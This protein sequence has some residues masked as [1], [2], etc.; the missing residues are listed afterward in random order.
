MEK[1]IRW[2]DRLRY[3]V[4]NSF[5]RG[6]IA[7]I[8][9]L[10][11]LSV[12]IIL[13]AAVLLVLTGFNQEG[14]EG[15]LSFGEAAWEAMMRAFD[16]GTLGGDTGWGYRFIMLFVTVGGVFIISTLIG[17]LTS[18]VEGKI[19]E[20][21]KGRSRVIESNHVVI[22]GWSEQIFTVLPE[23]ILANENQKQA[24]IVILAEKDKI[25]MEDAIR[26]RIG[27]SGHTRIICRTGSPLEMGDL[28]IVSINRSRA[29]VLLAPE[30]EDSDSEVI[31]TILAI[32]H[33]PQRR[34]EP[35][36]IVA[37]LRNPHNKAVAQVV[38]PGEV[39]WILTGDLIARIVAQTCRQSGLSI[40]YNELLDFGGDEIY[41]T[42]AG[43][44]AGKTYRAALDGFEKNAV[45]GY[46]PA[47]G[48][49][50]LNP[51][52][53]TVLTAGDQLVVLA[54]DDDQIFF[55]TAARPQVQLQRIVTTAPAPARPEKDLVLGWNWRAAAIIRELD[56]Y[57]V[58]G[59]ELLVLTRA[60]AA[61]AEMPAGLRNLQV[62]LRPADITDRATLE[63]IGVAQVDHMILLSELEGVSAQQADSRTLITLLHLRDIADRAGLNLSITSEM[64]DVRNR[65]LA[66]VTRADDFIVSNHLVSL[67]LSK[68]AENKALNAVFE[69]LF[70]AKG[71]EVYLKPVEN[72]ILPGGGP[73]NFYTVIEA[74]HRQNETALGYRVHALAGDAEQ[75]YGVRLN[76]AKSAE[77]Q[78]Q[79]GDRVVVIAEN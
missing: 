37:E 78:F 27:S 2:T 26:E 73:V 39:E 34:K 70:D 18:G 11:G 32:V 56:Q 71:S 17:V 40:V 42:P 58:P 64:I 50:R 41:F 16:A 24:A 1:P 30:S 19:E 51:P 9:W 36:H 77:V 68:I 23:L 66:E 67:I 35:F 33:D 44:L 28:Q 6:T 62:T 45:L 10:G 22:L 61:A 12:V 55:N 7:L 79:P 60:A 63:S 47:G 69:D 75:A 72:Y 49:P 31:K 38:G 53:D 4:D 76:P 59:S 25:E 5:S 52:H 65:N 8:A 15:G 29:V 14:A 3:W 20:L 57:V 46:C 43:P 54:A 48:E 74:A 13:I 21:R